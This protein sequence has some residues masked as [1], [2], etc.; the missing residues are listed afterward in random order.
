MVVLRLDASASSFALKMLLFKAVGMKS[1]V[2]E[3]T[4]SYFLTTGRTGHPIER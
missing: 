4:G 3:G 1:D 2:M